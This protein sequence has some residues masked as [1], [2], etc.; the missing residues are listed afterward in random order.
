MRFF[1]GLAVPADKAEAT[2]DAIRREGVLKR[3]GRWQM[4]YWHPGPIEVLF[5]KPGLSLD[6]TRPKD[7]VGLPAVCGCGDDDGAAYYA[8]RHNRGAK[9]NTPVMVEFEAE[10]S[11]VA[12]DGKDCLYTVFQMGDPERARDF[13][14]K[15]FGPR[16]LRYAEKAWLLDETLARVALC[17]LAIH[18]PAIVE[19][20]HANEVVI[21]GRYNTIFRSAFTIALPIKAAQIIRAW[22]PDEEPILPVPEVTLRDLTSRDD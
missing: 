6:D 13:L 22:L 16:V 17:D 10:R 3:P 19:A 14:R 5:T 21:G 9:D 20:H 1:R 15:A 4:E 8:W 2:A 18:D 7:A 12:V 11:C